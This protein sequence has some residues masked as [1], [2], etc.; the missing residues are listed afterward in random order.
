MRSTAPNPGLF[1]INGSRSRDDSRSE[2]K[3][4]PELQNP[5]SRDC[6]QN[7]SK[8]PVDHIPVRIRQIDSIKQVEELRPELQADSFVNRKNLA[9]QKIHIREAGAANCVAPH[10]AAPSQ[11]GIGKRLLV[12][13]S[14]V[15]LLR[16]A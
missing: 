10:V 15:D 14:Y 6:P 11:R 1:W 5:G 12:E 3:F 7:L 8:S 2:L 9:E 13:E 16:T 4:Q